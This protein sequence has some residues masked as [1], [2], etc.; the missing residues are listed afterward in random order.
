MYPLQLVLV[1]EQRLIDAFTSLCKV[2]HGYYPPIHVLLGLST[3]V[4]CHKVE[5]RWW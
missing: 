2:A 1:G 3:D 5:Q 4:T